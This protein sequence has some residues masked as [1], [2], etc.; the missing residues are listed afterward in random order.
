MSRFWFLMYGLLFWA[1][2]PWAHSDHFADPLGKPNKN[3]EIAELET[4]L[5]QVEQATTSPEDRRAQLRP[6]LSS[7]VQLLANLSDEPAQDRSKVARIFRNLVRVL[8]DWP[9][10]WRLV[11]KIQRTLGLHQ[12]SPYFQ[13]HIPNLL[14]MVVVTES[15]EKALIFVLPWL[16]NQLG[17]VSDP[18]ALTGLGLVGFAVNQVD[19]ICWMNPFVYSAFPKLQRFVTT[20]R[21]TVDRY[22]VKPIQ[23][24]FSRQA[25]SPGWKN[26][27]LEKLPDLQISVDP[28][29]PNLFRVEVEGI[30]DSGDFAWIRRDPFSGDA[31]LIAY[32]RTSP[33][34]IRN[35]NLNQEPPAVFRILGANAR[36][37]IRRVFRTPEARPF[38]FD[39]WEIQAN[40]Q[41]DFRVAHFR[42]GAIPVSRKWFFWKAFPSCETA[43]I[44]DGNAISPEN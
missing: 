4:R 16:G 27:W 26:H 19:L 32:G 6:L 44:G 39:R 23:N 25:L 28:H 40:G 30:D 34:A 15:A 29:D 2:P 12:D 43:L 18:M 5:A 13:E 3:A 33:N 20:T 36:D 24:R 1:Q 22:F 35:G 37:A 31:T 17:G 42:K 21:M 14:S 41:S 10:P 9:R 8:S 38:Y 11:Y 7:V